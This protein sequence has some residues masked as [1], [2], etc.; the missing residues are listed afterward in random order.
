MASYRGHL[1]C[2]TILGAAFGGAAAWQFQMN[3]GPA[4]LGAGV[5]AV[6]GLLPDL[7]SDS[8][9]PVRELFGLAAAATPLLLFAR[10]E[11]SGL[12]LEQVL[13]VLGGIY[14]FIR[15]GISAFFKRLTIHRGMFHSIPAMFIAGLL[16]F[17]A[18]DS[19]NRFLRGYLAVGVMLGFLSHLILDE[20]YG[21]DL[22][23]RRVQP[24][25]FA[26]SP[27]KMY[28]GSWLATSFCY[29]LLAG[30]GYLAY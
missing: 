15:Y 28:S 11:N 13:V 6:G 18:Y 25:S 23:G 30:L 19:P 24:G 14:L 1:T 2:S 16:V 26:G 9:V 4:F 3:W 8:G 10:L 27:L 21:I 29:L 12:A 22:L 5:T 7:D 20:I 17:L